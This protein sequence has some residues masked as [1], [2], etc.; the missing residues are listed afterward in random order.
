MS[1]T[2]AGRDKE[3]PFPLGFQAARE[4]AGKPTAPEHPTISELHARDEQQRFTTTVQQFMYSGK[5]SV[6]D[7]Q[8]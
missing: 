1:M 2:V 4:P 5:G 8:V 6:I 7:D 3:L